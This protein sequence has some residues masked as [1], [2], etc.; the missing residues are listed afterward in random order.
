MLLIKLQSLSMILIN[1]HLEDNMINV[2]SKEVEKEPVAHRRL[3]HHQLH[4]LRL[5]PDQHGHA[6][7]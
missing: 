7:C 2:L 1:T 3:L 4:A 6:D 5:D